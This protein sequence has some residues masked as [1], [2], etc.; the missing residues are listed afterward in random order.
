MRDIKVGQPLFAVARAGTPIQGQS[1]PFIVYPAVCLKVD[2]DGN[3]VY[4]VALDVYG[5]TTIMKYNDDDVYDYVFIN[6]EGAQ[7]HA[8]RRN[9]QERDNF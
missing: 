9:E 4:E 1:F 6:R 3:F 8:D 7:A 5:K 2:Y